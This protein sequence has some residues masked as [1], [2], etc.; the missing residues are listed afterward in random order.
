MNLNPNVDNIAKCQ[1][2]EQEASW[3]ELLLKAKLGELLQIALLR[4]YGDWAGVALYLNVYNFI[5]TALL[6]LLIE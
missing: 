2:E 5:A 3:D 6:G 1:V 4:N